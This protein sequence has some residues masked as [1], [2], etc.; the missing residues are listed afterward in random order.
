MRSLW[1]AIDHV[2]VQRESIR[3][4]YLY[5]CVSIAMVLIIGVWFLSL[6]ESFQSITVDTQAVGEQLSQTIVKPATT[7]SLSDLVEQGKNITI[8]KMPTDLERADF[9]ENQQ[10]AK[11]EPFDEREM[12][13][14]NANV[15]IQ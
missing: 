11:T 12:P 10:K 7:P 1:K 8:D 5:G 13:K 4:R 14:N 15:D 6:H 9:F 2:R 3:R